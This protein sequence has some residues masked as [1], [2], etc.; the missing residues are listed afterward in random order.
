MRVFA[1]VSCLLAAISSALAADLPPGPAPAPPPVYA[2]IPVV[3][4]YNWSGFYIGANG[5]Y[6]FAPATATATATSFFGAA[7]ATSSATLTGPLAGGQIGF[8]WQINSL[9]L[10]IEVDGDWSNQNNT[11]TFVSCFGLCTV[12]GT[13]TI[14]WFATARGRVGYAFDR[15]LIYGTGG[16]AWMNASGNLTASG[17]GITENLASISSSAFGFAAGGG[18]EAAIT[19]NLSLRAEYL[20]LYSNS[21]SASTTI[22]V[23]GATLTEKATISDNV[24][25]AGLNWRFPIGWL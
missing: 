9:V 19:P 7:A 16:G 13:S 25:R 21:F 6:G 10:G 12:S 2:P 20:Y 8:N 14:N 1:A 3:P 15:I 11:T 24:I 17:F 22:P 23:L 4:V 5:G 18:I